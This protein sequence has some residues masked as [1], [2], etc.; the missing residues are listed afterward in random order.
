MHICVCACVNVCE[1]RI[2][3]S[4]VLWAICIYAHTICKY[5]VLYT[6]IYIYIYTHTYIHIYI[7][8]YIY[9]YRYRERE[10]GW[11][12][13]ILIDWLISFD[14]GLQNQ[15]YHINLIF[16]LKRPL[17]DSSI[18][19]TASRIQ[20]TYSTTFNP[21]NYSTLKGLNYIKCPYF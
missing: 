18:F 17:L 3:L 20:I 1:S 8:I 16:I 21:V 9:I 5:C 15:V 12:R 14:W 7:C 4:Q 6:Y 13:E 10:R 11:E 19:N 2:K